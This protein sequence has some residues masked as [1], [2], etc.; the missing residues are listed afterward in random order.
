MSFVSVVAIS[1]LLLNLPCPVFS[2]DQRYLNCSSSLS[3]GNITNLMYP[4]YGLNRANY[5]GQPGFK[6]DCQN[7]VPFIKIGSNQYKYRVVDSN[8]L[9]RIITVTRND[10]WETTCPL[11]FINTTFDPYPFHY[12]AGFWNLTLFYGCIFNNWPIQGLTTGNVCLINDTTVNMFYSTTTREI[13]PGLGKCN[14]SVIVPVQGK[15]AL[16]VNENKTTVGK[17]IEEGVEVFWDEDV[18]KC[19]ICLQSGGVCGFNWTQS[20][21]S[22]FCYDHPSSTSCPTRP[23]LQSPATKY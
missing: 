10:Y 12:I 22:C 14:S 7:E 17:A 3:C 6:L 21:F 15:A 5:C 13:G 11:D 20:L 1:I 19:T 4:F 18:D 2:N 9:Q 23:G 8:P 16:A